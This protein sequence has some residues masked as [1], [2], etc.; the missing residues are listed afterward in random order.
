MSSQKKSYSIGVIA[1]R[2]G[3]SVSA[4]RHYEAEGLIICGR[5]AGGKRVL[6]AADIRRLSF[7]MIAQKLGFSLKQIRTH[8]DALPDGR[9]PT[10]KD[11]DQISRT[12]GKEIDARIDALQT[13]REKLN[14]CIGCGCLSLK[15]CA[16]YNPD[17]QIAK[18]GSGPRYLMG[19]RP[20]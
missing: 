15:T 17:D 8:L 2:T 11:W 18:K 16:L 1:A 12:F 5:N 10:K 14:G 4:I 13:L 19:D 9:A 7:I 20:L 3:L 6:E